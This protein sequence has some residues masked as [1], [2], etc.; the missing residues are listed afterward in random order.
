[1][2]VFRQKQQ[3]SE[4]LKA[5]AKVKMI[6]LWLR[7]SDSPGGL[8]NAVF[9]SWPLFKITCE[10]QDYDAKITVVFKYYVICQIL[11]CINPR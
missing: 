6:F 3:L 10:C 11:A 4:P 5:Q 8:N 1:M 7:M 2:Y 9:F